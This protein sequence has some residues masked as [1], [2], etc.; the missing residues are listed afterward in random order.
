MRLR[1]VDFIVGGLLA[2]STRPWRG[3]GLN[4]ICG[5]CGLRRSVSAVGLRRSAFGGRLRQSA[6]AVGFGSRPSAVG[7]GLRGAS[8]EFAP[9]PARNRI[10][11]APAALE[12]HPRRLL[13]RGWAALRPFAHA[14]V[15]NA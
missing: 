2:V 14:L 9:P 7:F 10:G 5:V 3:D 12:A 15:P 13:L 8:P 4:S 11:T 6:S 1:I